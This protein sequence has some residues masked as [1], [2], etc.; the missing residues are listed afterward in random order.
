MYVLTWKDTHKTEIHRAGV[1]NSSTTDI[2]GHG[3][4]CCGGRPGHCKV[5]SSTRGLPL[6]TRFQYIL[7]LQLRTANVPGTGSHLKTK[8]GQRNQ[9]REKLSLLA[10]F[11]CGFYMLLIPPLRTVKTTVRGLTLN[12]HH[13]CNNRVQQ[14]LRTRILEKS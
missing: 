3:N 7:H 5:L 6:P 14:W 2:L 9:I 11:S 13:Q 10:L 8:Q 4:I 12:S 1:L